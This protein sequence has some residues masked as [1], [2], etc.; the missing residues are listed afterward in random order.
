MSALLLT[1]AFLQTSFFFPFSRV[2]AIALFCVKFA[3]KIQ[4]EENNEI[5]T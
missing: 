4:F 1:R 3:L 5:Y 2:T